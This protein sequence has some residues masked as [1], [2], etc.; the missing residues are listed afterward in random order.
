[1]ASAASP[2]VELA[3]A[4]RTVVM[5]CRDVA[6]ATKRARRRSSGRFPGREVHVVHC[7]LASLASVRRSAEVA[8]SHV[9]AGSIC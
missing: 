4:G 7:D 1:M 5:L 9:R 6:A 3:M 8:A 2:A